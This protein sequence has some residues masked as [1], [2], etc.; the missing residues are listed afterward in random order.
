MEHK[1]ADYKG[2]QIRYDEDEDTW[3]GYQP[4]G[5]SKQATT[6]AKLK[7]SIDKT[8]KSDKKFVRFDAFHFGNSLTDYKY[9][10]VTVTSIGEARN[11]FG[12]PTAYVTLA[13]GTRK[14]ANVNELYL[15]TPEN[16]TLIIQRATVLQQI[17]SLQSQR[18][19]LEKSIQPARQYIQEM[20]PDMFK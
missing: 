2:Y 20:V 3:Y 12:L 1:L 10:P 7:K 5:K 14:R 4:E 8:E 9:V 19:L 11:I 15:A 6:L 17:A 13:D 16:A 18:H